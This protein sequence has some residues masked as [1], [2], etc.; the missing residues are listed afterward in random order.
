MPKSEEAL[1]MYGPNRW[2]S[3]LE[4]VDNLRNQSSEP[5]KLIDQCWP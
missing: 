5:V 3:M 2:V 4:Q 1:A